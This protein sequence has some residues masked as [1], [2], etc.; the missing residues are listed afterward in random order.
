[1]ARQI[2]KQRIAILRSNSYEA[3]ISGYLN[4]SVHDEVLGATGTRYDI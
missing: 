3:L 4:R 2:A 1:M